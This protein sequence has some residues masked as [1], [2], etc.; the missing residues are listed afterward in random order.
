MDLARFDDWVNSSQFTH[1]CHLTLFKFA[2]IVAKKMQE[3]HSVFTLWQALFRSS[4]NLK[5]VLFHFPSWYLVTWWDWGWRCA[6]SILGDLMVTWW[7]WGWGC[8]C[9]ILGDLMGLGLKVCMQH[10]GWLDETGAEGVHAAFWVTW[11]WLDGTGA[12]GVHAAFWAWV[13]G[14]LHDLYKKN[15]PFSII[16]M[17]MYY[18]HHLRIRP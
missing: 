11:W 4:V 5:I 9:S 3:G 15:Y 16:V 13:K 7:D 18:W 8:A 12:E 6:Y 1:S 14:M 17:G 2:Q 10:F